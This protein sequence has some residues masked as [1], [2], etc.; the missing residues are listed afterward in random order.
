MEDKNK[1]ESMTLKESV[2]K[3]SCPVK[4]VPMLILLGVTLVIL[5]I[6]GYFAI[7]KEN[8][9]DALS[10]ID[11][12]LISNDTLLDETEDV[13]K[14]FSDLPEDF[15]DSEVVSTE[16]IDT[17]VEEIDKQLGELDS[18]DSDFELEESDIG[19]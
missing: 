13:E 9:E 17:S 18:L 2:M 10:F 4:K 1:Q 16:E 14:E 12:I 11:R 6:L 3:K 7:G 15:L 19:L 8:R 5:V